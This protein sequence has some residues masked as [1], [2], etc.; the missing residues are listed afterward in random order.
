MVVRR[1]PPSPLSAKSMSMGRSIRPQKNRDIMFASICGNHAD[2]FTKLVMLRSCEKRL[3]LE[4]ASVSKTGKGFRSRKILT[5]CCKKSK[6]EDVQVWRFLLSSIETCKASM[7]NAFAVVA[8]WSATTLTS[9]HGAS[10]SCL[11]IKYLFCG[12]V[13]IQILLAKFVTRWTIGM[14]LYPVQ[15]LHTLRNLSTGSFRKS[16]H[17]KIET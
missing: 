13:K 2:H 15:Y 12:F 1:N 3:T 6:E 16:Q 7:A 10:T 11:T 8:A 9:L 14:I 4:D 17:A 5:I